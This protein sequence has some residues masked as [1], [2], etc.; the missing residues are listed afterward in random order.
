M[1]YAKEQAD[2]YLNDIEPAAPESWDHAMGELRKTALAAARRRDK[3]EA[4]LRKIAGWRGYTYTPGPT[5]GN[6]EDAGRLTEYET[7]AND[8]LETLKQMA[9]EA[10]S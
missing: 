8:M 9:E 1:T 4:A 6:H 10:L 5:W 3:Y 2:D 7:G